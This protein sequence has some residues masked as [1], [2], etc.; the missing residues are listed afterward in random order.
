MTIE[1]ISPTPPEPVAT[2]MMLQRWELVSF[3][4]WRFDAAE[5]RML[6][7]P[8]LEIDVFD[9]SAWV[10][11]VPF[12][13]ISRVTGTPTIPWLSTFAETNVRTY[14]I[15]PDG[16][17][18]IW[19]LSLDVG[20]S[21]VAVA[22]AMLGLPYRWSRMDVEGVFGDVRYRAR[23]IVPPRA[24]A[25]SRVRVI[26]NAAATATSPLDHF[27]TARFRLYGTGPLGLF[28]V[29]VEHRPWTLHPGRATELRDGFVPATGLG[30]PTGDPLV[31]HSM[32]LRDVRVGLPERVRPVPGVR[33][34]L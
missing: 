7:P 11:L 26:S 17:R 15:G 27:L 21:P 22:G 5:L 29:P 9:G 2:P 28:A 6:V 20:R 10:G 25:E 1:P 16:R 3:V 30:P 8:E 12:R 14:V 32:G 23:R 4:H 19:F 18:G 13:M 33:V 34:Q 24:G 31:H